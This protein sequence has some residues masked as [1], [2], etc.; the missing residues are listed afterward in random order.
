[1]NFI[2]YNVFIYTNDT[3][4]EYIQYIHQVFQYLLDYDLYIKLEKYEFHVQETRFLDFI[5]FSSDIVMNFECIFIIID[6]STF[7]S[8]HD[9]QMFLEF[10]NFYHRFIDS[11]SHEILA[12]TILLRKI[13]SAFQW[14]FQAQ[15]VF[16][17]LKYLFTQASI[18]RHFDPE[19]SIYLY[20]DVSGFAISGIICQFHNGNLHSITF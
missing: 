16:E 14:I 13:S 8:I 4:E 10:C 7:N 20:I 11:Y 12:M 1:M 6:W 3:H 9:I 15:K 2:S 17:Y 5:I 18:L 19:I